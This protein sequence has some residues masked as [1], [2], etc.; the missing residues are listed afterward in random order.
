MCNKAC[1]GVL[2]CDKKITQ[3]T[4]ASRRCVYFVALS[5]MPV[6]MGYI[7]FVPSCGVAPRL[8][9]DLCGVWEE[10]LLSRR[11]VF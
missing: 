4:M 3:Q 7:A 1:V 5:A 9:E 6:R 8:G 2:F 11:A 10:W